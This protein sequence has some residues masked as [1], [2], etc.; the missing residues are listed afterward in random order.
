M[1]IV[2]KFLILATLIGIVSC[3]KEPDWFAENTTS[4]DKFAPFIYMYA[5]DSAS[6]TPGVRAKVLLE[7]WCIDPIKEIRLYE[8]RGATITTGAR[9]L[10]ATIPYQK[11]FSQIRQMDTLVTQYTV[12]ASDPKGTRIWLHAEGVST[13][14]Y[15][16]GTWVTPTASR[17]FT[18]K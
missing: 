6:F 5:L 14:D 11:A 10:V 12:P 7:Y 17:S 4:Q 2:S 3:Y 18:T 8:S 1:K 13:K 9:T 15:A 16:K